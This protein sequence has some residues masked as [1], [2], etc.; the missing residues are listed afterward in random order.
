MSRGIRP[1]LEGCTVAMV[2][3]RVRNSGKLVVM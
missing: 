2:D 1:I 3:V